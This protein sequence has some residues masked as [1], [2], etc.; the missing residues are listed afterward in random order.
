MAIGA[1]S[2]RG[3]SRMTLSEI[4]VT[5]LVDVMLVLLII[6]MVAAPMM[7]HGVPVDLPQTTAEVM[8]I[9]EQ[10]LL[11]SITRE[12]KVFLGEAE[13]PYARLKSALLSNARLQR[14]KELYVR[15]DAE[16][17]YGFAMQVLS[18]VKEAGIEKLGLVTDPANAEHP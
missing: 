3:A 12:R 6:F 11:L 7:T 1:G 13:I 18:I 10:K 5:P 9:D 16:V 17:A 4:N 15:A 2:T 14:E 8:P